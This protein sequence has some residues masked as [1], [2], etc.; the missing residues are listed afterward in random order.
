MIIDVFLP[1]ALAF[2]MISLGLGLTVDDFKWVTTAP[3]AFAVGATDLHRKPRTVGLRAGA[4]RH[5]NSRQ[6][7]RARR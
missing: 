4:H 7:S 6:Q 2:F 3:L 1:L 5:G